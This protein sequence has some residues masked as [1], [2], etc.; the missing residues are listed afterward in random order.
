MLIEN[1][2]KKVLYFFKRYMPNIIKI[3][4]YFLT[5]LKN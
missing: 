2:S 3:V 5:N 1:N 4:K